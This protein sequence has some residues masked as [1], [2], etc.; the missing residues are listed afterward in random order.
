MKKI[1]N[2]DEAF[3][4]IFR[5]TSVERIHVF[6]KA[7]G[8]EKE[9]AEKIYKKI[10]REVQNEE[11]LYNY[12]KYNSFVTDEQAREIDQIRAFRAY[13]KRI[14]TETKKH[15]IIR[16]MM[17]EIENLRKKHKF[18]WVDVQN[19]IKKYKRMKISDRYIA[20]IY[21]EIKK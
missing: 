13:K 8:V 19:Y 12:K 1:I 18:S 17:P 15:R 9:E 2:D 7:L 6:Q 16:L 21:I 14:I 20:K 4:K 3:K 10:V 11:L 5:Y